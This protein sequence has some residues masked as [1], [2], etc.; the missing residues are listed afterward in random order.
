[1]FGHGFTISGRLR[2]ACQEVANIDYRIS[3]ILCVYKLYMR[4]N[5]VPTNSGFHLLITST[6]SRSK[7][8]C[9]RCW[10]FTN[11]LRRNWWLLQFAAKS[12]HHPIPYLSCSK[13]HLP[14]PIYFS[15]V[16]YLASAQ[17]FYVLLRYAFVFSTQYKN[18]PKNYP[19]SSAPYIKGLLRRVASKCPT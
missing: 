14:F 6:C 2:A 1:M 13:I 16:A 18:P 5:P 8:Y 15:N 17:T 3:A 4:C 9:I 19:Q 7:I 11:C 12:E 10:P